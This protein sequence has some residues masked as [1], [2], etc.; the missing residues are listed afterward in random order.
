MASSLI[1]PPSWWRQP[2][3]CIHPEYRVDIKLIENKNIEKTNKKKTYN[4]ALLY[5]Y[6][7]YCFSFQNKNGRSLIVHPFSFQLFIFQFVL[8]YSLE[9]F[10]ILGV[11]RSIK[12]SS[13]VLDCAC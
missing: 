9:S 8:N 3:P 10:Y 6:L 13:R 12:P 2:W 4:A 5:W 1:P 11:I 7:F